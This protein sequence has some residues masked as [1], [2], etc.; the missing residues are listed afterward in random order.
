MIFGALILASTQ[1]KKKPVHH[2]SQPFLNTQSCEK[3]K[4]ERGD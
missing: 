1:K 4:N 3:P 2:D